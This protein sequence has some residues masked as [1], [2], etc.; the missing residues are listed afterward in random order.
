MNIPV[1]VALVSLFN[2]PEILSS[3]D[4]RYV[5]INDY[6]QM[7]HY[8]GVL[9]VSRRRFR[10]IMTLN[11]S[12]VFDLVDS[13]ELPNLDLFIGD[14]RSFIK[15]MPN[16]AFYRDEMDYRLR[17]WE[18]RMVHS[19]EQEFDRALVESTRRSRNESSHR[20][21]TEPDWSDDRLSEEESTGILI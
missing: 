14:E 11:T 4:G 1:Y 7:I 6:G 3:N 2:P 5:S 8:A 20:I 12:H 21:E 18:Y 13:R 16:L 15:R 10:W 9:H 17:S 19:R